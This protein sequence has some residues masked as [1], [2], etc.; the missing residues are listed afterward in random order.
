[1]TDPPEVSVVLATS[2]GGS[3]I[4]EQLASLATQVDAP[5]FEIV[6]VGNRAGDAISAVE[7]RWASRLPIRVVRADDRAGLSYAR[8][9][10]V[11]AAK[12]RKLL[13]L[14]DD[15]AVSDTYVRAMA[16]ALDEHGAVGARIDLHR[17]NHGWRADVRAV[18]Q[19]SGLG[20]GRTPF[21]YGATLGARR[22][23]FDRVGGF[24]ESLDGIAGEDVEWCERLAA[25]G[26]RL[27]F[28]PD[29]VL[30]YR[31]RTRYRDLYRQ[32]FRYGRGGQIVSPSWPGWRRWVRSL[33]G[34][35]RLLTLGPGKGVRRR[36]V[37]LLGRRLGQ[38]TERH[39]GGS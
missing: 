37:F 24:D 2:G 3:T 4:D 33:V 14:D 27:V 11:A 36:G 13:F 32:G 22:E 25:A 38:A 7:E 35:L 12:G 34:P 18:P 28:V 8:N 23:V 21:A 1:M 39:Q 30:H 31:L 19:T 10:G 20:G 17:F 9:T 5:P 29:A 15:D 26:E 16:A 6:L